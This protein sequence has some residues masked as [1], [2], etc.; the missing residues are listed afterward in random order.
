MAKINKLATLTMIGSLL[1]ATTQPAMSAIEINEEEFGPS[2]ETMAADAVVGKPLQLVAAVAGTATYVVSLPFSVAGG[3]AEQAKRKL[4]T[5]PWTAMNRCLGCTV[6]ED[7][8]YKSQNIDPNAT[9]MVIGDQYEISIKTDDNVIVE[10][11]SGVV[12]EKQ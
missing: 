1:L 2:Y 4:V 12:T 6:S 8:Y 9:R 11:P 3:N 7:K 10:D 5:E